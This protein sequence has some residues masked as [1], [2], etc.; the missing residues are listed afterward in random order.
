MDGCLTATLLENRTHRPVRTRS[1]EGM[2][3]SG[4]Q[5]A[6]GFRLR[7]VTFQLHG[8]CAQ[9]GDGTGHARKHRRVE[10]F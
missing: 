4:V 9:F 3:Q 2:E 6:R 8:H 1:G 7:C 5:T 10:A